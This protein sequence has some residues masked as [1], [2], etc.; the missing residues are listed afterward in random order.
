METATEN[1]TAV[2]GLKYT[3]KQICDFVAAMHKCYQAERRACIEL[4]ER[5]IVVALDGV[6][7]CATC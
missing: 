3:V 6:V 5:E 7:C 4:Q 2:V 1:S